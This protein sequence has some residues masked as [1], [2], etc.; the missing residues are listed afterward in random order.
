MTV[1]GSGGHEEKVARKTKQKKVLDAAHAAKRLNALLARRD[2]SVLEVKKRLLGDGY[3]PEIVES[4]IERALA[5]GA[6]NDFRFAEYYVR[7]RVSAG[8]GQARIERELAK[9]GIAIDSLEGWP[10]AYIE[11]DEYTRALKLLEHKTIPQKNAYQ[12]FARFLV[13][14][15]YSSHIAHIAVTHWLSRDE[16]IG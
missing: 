11:D 13:G 12:K 10:A 4:L 14:K 9:K 15:G 8:Y 16:C 3:S 6:L 2:Y 1:F 5:G 7:A